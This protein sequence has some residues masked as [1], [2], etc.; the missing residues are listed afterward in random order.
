LQE[1]LAMMVEPAVSRN[2]V[3]NVERGRT[4]PHR[5]TLDALALALGLDADQRA[6]LAA[7][8][9]TAD[10]EAEDAESSLAAGRVGAASTRLTGGSPL[11]RHNLP[12]PATPLIG[13]EQEL[14][15]IVARVCSPEAGL[16][17]LTGAG[18]I[19]KTR[20]A[21]EA[22]AVM[23]DDFADGVVFVAL[24]PITDPNLVVAAISQALGVPDAGNSLRD[25]LRD[26]LRDKRVLL[27][28]DNFEH[29]LPAGTLLPALLTEAPGLNVLVTSREVLRVSREETL[30]VPPMRLPSR[31]ALLPLEQLTQYEAVRLFIERARAVKPDFPM[32]NAG[33]VAAAEICQRVDGLP[34]AIE[35]AAARVRH[36][37]P[38]VLLP[39][40]ERRLSV[41][42][43]GARDLPARHQTLRGAIAWSYDLLQ[44]QEQALFRRLAVFAGGCTLEAAEAVCVVD[45]SSTGGLSPSFDVLDGVASLVDKSLIQVRHE[46]GAGGELRYT[47]LETV[48]EYGREQLS[49]AGD[50][51]TTRARHAEYYESLVQRA[52]PHFLRAEQLT[53]LAR[54]DDELD[55]LRVV[56]QWL[57]DHDRRERGQ[58][59]AGSLWYFW[60]IH[61]R[62][63][64]GRVWL[65]RLLAGPAGNATL[66]RP[67]AQALLALGD[68]LGRQFDMVAADEVSNESLALARHAGDAW[69]TARA[70]VRSAVTAER[71]DDWRSLPPQQLTDATTAARPGP[72]ERYEEAVAIMRRLDDQ[73]G[74]AMSLAFFAQF[75]I[76]RDAARARNLVDE[77]VEIARRLGERWAISF[78]LGVLGRLAMNAGELTEA[79]QLFE[80]GILLHGELNDL[81]SESQ[82]L[83][84]LA[85][86]ATDEARFTD[87]L[88]LHERCVA[89]YRL[90]G[91]RPR[92]A[93]ALHDLAIAARLVGDAERAH[94]AYDESLGVFQDLGQRGEVGAVRASLGHLQR[95]AGAFTRAARTFAESLRILSSQNT[96]LGIATVLAGLG[97]IALDAGRPTEAAR[98]IGSAEALLERLQMDPPRV[99]LYPSQAGA[100]RFQFH[101]DTV[102]ARELR[103][104]GRTAFEAMGPEAFESA[105]GVGHALSSAEAVAVGLE[106]AER[107]AAAGVE[108]T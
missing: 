7:A 101:R 100:R 89:N 3:G 70:L 36:V 20:L 83:G 10:A 79:R 72:E 81:Y 71:L 19:G 22:A 4:R 39:R 5:H 26:F 77:A 48:R 15:A 86:L 41:L 27:V 88:S 33:I 74:T 103:A 43:G 25:N 92:L 38:E 44:P 51:A 53:W 11:R 57:L 105:L 96:E 75:L 80:Q 54:M 29:L 99:D 58:L 37:A 90:L 76:L 16:L 63:S 50:E 55:N 32:T 40:L 97:N 47:M 9:R 102:H 28:L 6:E 23:L 2:T 73:W 107:G 66:A 17:T 8:W 14:A 104:T 94:Q 78:S 108:R 106:L 98:L 61:S 24:A 67:R 13:R 45:G 46:P 69:T 60:S 56:L 21:L 68:T 1:E 34:L 87:A 31:A 82:K 65:K 30:G 84:W 64:E 91:N 93:H 42:T 49:A 62:V 35:L 18:G 95:Q 12:T 59:L 85:Q 52:A